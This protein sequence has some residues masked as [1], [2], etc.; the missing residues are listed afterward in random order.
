MENKKL[1]VEEIE[2][3]SSFQQR[4]QNLT[5]EVGNIELSIANLQSRKDELL[6]IFSS[7]RQEE[8]AFGQELSQK[9]GNGT[10]DLEKGELTPN[11]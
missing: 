4:A 10:I 1:T 5:L 2:K 8:N 11:T 3:L 6:K 9:Y 7:Y